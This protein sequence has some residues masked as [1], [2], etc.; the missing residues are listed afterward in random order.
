MTG[1]VHE[2]ARLCHVMGTA[3][4]S[5][6]GWS[7]QRWCE[8]VGVDS[9]GEGSCVLRSSEFGLPG[10]R[11]GKASN[12][13]PRVEGRRRVESSVSETESDV[14]FLAGLQEDPAWCRQSWTTVPLSASTVPASSRVL[15]G[16]SRG[17]L[18]Q[19]LCQVSVR[20]QAIFESVRRVDPDRPDGARTPHGST[21]TTGTSFGFGV[22][23]NRHFYR[24]N[25]CLEK[26]TLSR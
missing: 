23:G 7:H 20:L 6:D 21:R 11:V 14:D 2:V 12:P 3:A 16:V 4:T 8:S 9:F 5:S 15:R 17:P 25:M 13:G 22:S 26:A 24:P 18:F 10:C 1:N 19:P